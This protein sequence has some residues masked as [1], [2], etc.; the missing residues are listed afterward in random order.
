MP[1]TTNK[2]GIKHKKPRGRHSHFTGEKLAYLDG[3]AEEFTNRKDRGT[4]Y[5]EAT[6]GLIDTFGYSRD[7]KAYVGA[8]TL[9][10]EEQV[11]YYQALRSVSV[12]FPTKLHLSTTY[13]DVG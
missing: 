12:H 4:F 9:S 2:T 10:T 3:L 7:G 11:E 5:D 13:A 1:K 8:D 6:Q